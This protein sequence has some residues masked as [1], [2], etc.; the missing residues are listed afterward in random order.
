VVLTLGVLS[1]VPSVLLNANKTLL[2]PPGT[3]NVL[4][5]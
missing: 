1:L 3:P 2:T 5:D 4:D